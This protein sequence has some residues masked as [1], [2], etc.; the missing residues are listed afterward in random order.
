VPAAVPPKVGESDCPGFWGWTGR[1]S[2]AFWRAAGPA[3]RGHVPLL[4]QSARRAPP[5]DNLRGLGGFAK[6]R[7]G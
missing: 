5:I 4:L 3:H 2:M 1:R 6:I 7:V